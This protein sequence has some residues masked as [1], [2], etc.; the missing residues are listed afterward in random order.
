MR[1]KALSPDNILDARQRITAAKR[2][3][4]GIE[5]EPVNNRAD[6]TPRR[7]NLPNGGAYVGEGRR[8]YEF[9]R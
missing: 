7:M 6:T 1:K 8:S 9:G 2:R 4:P 5:C 3:S